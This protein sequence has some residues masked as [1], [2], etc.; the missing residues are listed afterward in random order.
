MLSKTV[1]A[2][3]VTV[4]PPPPCMTAGGRSRFK[5]T[6]Q[7][8]ATV[9]YTLAVPD[10]EVDLPVERRPRGGGG[11]AHHHSDDD[12]TLRPPPQRSA[13]E[14]A[15]ARARARGRAL[16]PR[17]FASGAAGNFAR[18]G[19]T[20]GDGA[21]SI[22]VLRAALLAQRRPATAPAPA[23]LGTARAAA[24]RHVHGVTAAAAD[25]NAAVD[26]IARPG[27]A[28]AAA[29]AARGK[30]WTAASER[31]GPGMAPLSLTQSRRRDEHGGGGGDDLRA[32]GAMKRSATR[33]AAERR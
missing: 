29:A 31:E 9:E 6:F 3:G 20:N 16:R 1:A 11:V 14:A 18:A 26:V 12:N 21:V 22:G 7:H 30:G 27:T 13:H 33:S 24:Q 32:G 19:D 17:D 15:V 28:A 8:Q 2:P 4:R 10:D 25:Y 5:R 23:R